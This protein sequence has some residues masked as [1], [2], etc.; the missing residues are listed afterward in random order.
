MNKAFAFLCILPAMVA[1]HAHCDCQKVDGGLTEWTQFTPCSTSCGPGT[2]ERVRFCAA[3]YP[4]FGGKDCSGS[5]KESEPCNLRP[6]PRNGGWG[7]W[8]Q[9]TCSKKCGGGVKINT[10]SCNKPAPSKCGKDCVG[11]TTSKPISCNTH[12]CPVWKDDCSQCQY[13]SLMKCTRKCRQRCYDHQDYIVDDKYCQGAPKTSEKDCPTKDCPAVYVWRYR[14]KGQITACRK[15]PITNACVQDCEPTCVNFHT[16]YVVNDKRC[17]GPKV[18]KVIPCN[19]KK[20]CP[21]IPPK[22]LCGDCKAKALVKAMKYKDPF[23]KNNFVGLACRDSEVHADLH[24]YCA[25]NKGKQ[26]MTGGL[27]ANDWW[28][29][30]CSVDGPWCKPCATR[31]LVFNSKCDACEVTADGPCSNVTRKPMIW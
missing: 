22:G 9:G 12:R 21:N 4:Q 28:W 14:C 27:P 25:A 8:I 30:H 16:A 15:H 6:C 29:I 5:L 23:R 24:A 18:K 2:K 26:T 3:P 1:A 17:K 20:G 13:N 7:V 19:D 31:G 11:A 10:R